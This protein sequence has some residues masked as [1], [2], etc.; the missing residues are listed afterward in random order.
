LD[1]IILGIFSMKHHHHSLKKE[2]NT[3]SS[4]AARSEGIKG[5]HQSNCRDRERKPQWC[6]KEET[7]PIGVATII[8]GHIA[9]FSP[10]QK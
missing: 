9:E 2:Y 7:T 4:T 5:F 6:L 3:S 1:I 10:Q 8:H